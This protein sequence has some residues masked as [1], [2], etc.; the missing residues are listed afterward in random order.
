[1][2]GDGTYT[3]AELAA[4]VGGTVVGDGERVLAGIRPLDDAAPEHLSFYHNR[5]YLESARASRAGALLVAEPGQFPGRDLL[6]CRE[7]YPAFAK[8]LEIFHPQHRPPTGVHPSAVV[9]PSARLGAGASVGPTAVVGER[10]VVGDRA[11]LG[12]GAIVGDDAEVGTDTWLHPH[13]VIEPRCRVGARCI[14][15][16]GVVVGSDGYGFATVGGTHHK[17]PQVGIVVVE[18]DVELGANVCVDRATLGETRIGR[19]TKVD[20]LVQVGHNVQV[21]EGCLLVA[22]AG[23]A[24]STKLGR[25]VVMAGQ[26]GAAGHLHLGDGTQ[27]TAQSGVMTDT[28]AR[29]VVSGMPARPQREF[30]RAMA[31]LFQL[32][33]LKRRVKGLEA[34]VARL[35][36]RAE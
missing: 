15:H 17:V 23:I 11:V 32:D 29:E 13:V 18:D 4:R 1:M 14:L 22:Q 9:A 31:N 21:G 27:V 24:G 25:Y 6:V 30:L 26:S 34:A 8:L 7:P 10:A 36:G 3:L 28:A 5:R 33:A 12:P 19:G 20:N 16:A 2:G 35:G